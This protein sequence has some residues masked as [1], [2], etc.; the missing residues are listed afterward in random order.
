MNINN[1]NFIKEIKNRNE[2]VLEY[3]VRNYGGKMK[4][5]INSILY[6]YPQDA[7]ECL[8]DSLHKIWEHIDSYDGNKSSF[9]N[10]ALVIAKYTALNRLKKLTN[11]EPLLDIDD[12]Q[13]PDSAYITDN[14]LFNEFFWELISCLNEE[15]KNLFIRLFWYGESYDEVSIKF[16][17][18]KKTLFNHVSRG[19]KKII[20]NN[21]GLFRKK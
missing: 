4:A 12:L 15:D 8:F 18:D 20:Q 2:K 19:R 1:E 5:A 16:N 14:E 21:P 9:S 17:R 6:S 11:I 7:E 13:I 10:W 3:V